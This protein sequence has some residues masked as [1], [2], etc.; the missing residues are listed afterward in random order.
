MRDSLEDEKA[1]AQDVRRLRENFNERSNACE[2]E[3]EGNSVASDRLSHCSLYTLA[4][5][6]MREAGV[7]MCA[8]CLPA[9]R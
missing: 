4:V 1:R 6:R 7:R 8:P 3:K 9:F 2:R 5:H